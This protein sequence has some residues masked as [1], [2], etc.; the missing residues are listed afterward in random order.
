MLAMKTGGLLARHAWVIGLVA[1]GCDGGQQPPDVSALVRACAGQRTLAARLTGGFEHG[2]CEEAGDATRGGVG[3]PHCSRRFDESTL[4]ELSRLVQRLRSAAGP[5][6]DAATLQ[7]AGVA[8]LLVGAPDSAV[9]HLEQAV[10]RAPADA[11]ILSDLAAAYLT[12][13][14]ALDDS[15]DLVRALGRSLDALRQDRGLREALFNKALALDA[16]G[17]RA[18]GAAWRDF[19]RSEHSAEWRAEARARADRLGNQGMAWH[20]AWAKGTLEDASRRGDAA[21]VRAVAAR[22]PQAARLAVEEEMLPAWAASYRAGRIGD[23]RARLAVAISIASALR[24]TGKDPLLADAL[25]HVGAL[26]QRGDSAQ[27][28]LLTAGLAAHGE[29]VAAYANN[30]IDVALERLGFAR[31][32]LAASGSPV[33]WWSL[34]HL[35]NCHYRREE[36]SVALAEL[37]EVLRQPH[38][39]TYPALQGRALWIMGVTRISLAQP[40]DALNAYRRSLASFQAARE[41]ESEVTLHALLADALDYAGEERAAWQQRYLALR[42]VR[43]LQNPRRRLAVL[44]DAATGALRLR[45]PESALI[46]QEEAVRI[47]KRSGNSLD[48]AEGLRLRAAIEAQCREQPH[49]IA[50]LRAA[51]RELRKLGDPALEQGV[52][53]ELLYVEG[54]LL[55]PTDP[56]R[57]R[58]LFVASTRVFHQTSFRARLAESYLHQA[59]A[60]LALHDPARAQAALEAGISSIESEWQWALA[61]RG[62]GLDDFSG[63]Y[64]E[65]RRRLFEEMLRLS[66]DPTKAGVSFD[67]AERLHSWGLLDQALRL[68]SSASYIPAL[69]SGRPLGHQVLATSLPRRTMLVEYAQLEDRLLI[70]IVRRLSLQMTVQRINRDIVDEQ[71]ERFHAALA[72][73]DERAI[74]RSLTDLHA[75]LVEPIKGSL[76]AGE[77]LVFVPDRSLSAVPFSAL[78]DRRTGRLLVQ[79]FPVSVVPSAGLYLQARSRDRTLKDLAAPRILVLGDPDFEVG[80]FPGLRRL[81]GAASEA[82]AVAALYPTARLLLASTATRERLLDLAGSSTV[83]HIAAHVRQPDGWP[84]VS[85]MALAPSANGSGALYAHEVLHLR[86]PQTRLFVLSACSSAKERGSSRISGFVRPLL[87]VGIPSVIGTLWQVDDQATAPL[88]EA[89]HQSYRRSGDAPSALRDAQLRLIDESADEP[90][91]RVETWGSFQAYGATNNPR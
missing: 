45:E 30:R 12:R 90:L 87:A 40:A 88:M 32:Q 63:I 78:R 24:D 4:F 76:T 35:A 82:K 16:L 7:A 52:A 21:G 23:A 61:H 44:T 26:Q 22:F 27:L 19:G 58:E 5:A 56:R 55:L 54:R 80:S 69:D 43:A 11:R 73:R 50:S 64:T 3:L 71:V 77:T 47:A 1:L 42:G 41:H 6:A 8:E 15:R 13:A 60:S 33:A 18:A 37:G 31:Q 91:R 74:E 25:A 17:L 34:V 68:P 14:Q 72:A 62:E 51:E 39:S 49:S 81:P 75:S 79:D 83:V 59:L 46:I 70:W 67:Y 89:F 28:D 20:W 9:R 38:V 65:Q 85:A 84:L 57:A 10:R 66:T 48:L 53:G 29:G 2:P 86:F 36:Y